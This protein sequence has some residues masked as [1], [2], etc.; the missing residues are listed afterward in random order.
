M[1]ALIWKEIQFYRKNLNSVRSFFILVMFVLLAFLDTKI[2]VLQITCYVI[3]CASL[4][5]Y[6][7][8]LNEDYENLL[9][10]KYTVKSVII[11]KTTCLLVVSLL[12]NFIF[13]VFYY[14]YKGL[15]LD[16]LNFSLNKDGMI[17]LL[18]FLIVIYSSLLFMATFLLLLGKKS[19]YMTFVPLGVVLVSNILHFSL[20]INTF[21]ALILL[22]ISIF[23][24]SHLTKEKVITRSMSL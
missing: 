12:I 5:T 14:I 17:S 18:G 16:F 20:L 3:A 1:K 9:S 11:S 4:F 24:I 15:S 22:F 13:I 21:L 10:L 6:N 8:F 19:S 2:D 7:V 23:T